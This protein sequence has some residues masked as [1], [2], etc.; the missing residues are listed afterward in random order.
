V[1]KTALLGGFILLS[2]VCAALAQTPVITG[3]EFTTQQQGKSVIGTVPMC[4]NPS[5]VAVPCSS[6]GGSGAIAT[7][8]FDS[9]PVTKANAVSGSSHAA[10]VSV[11]GLFTIPVAR[12]AGGSGIITNFS[13]TSP[14]GATVTYAVR[15]WDK[16]PASTTCTDNTNFAGNATDDMNLIVPP[17]SITPAPP[18]STQG[19]AKTYASVAGI[20]WDYKNADSPASQNLYGC[21]VATATDTADENTS[22]VMMLAGPQN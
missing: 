15:I 14:G 5:N 17:F 3:N 10:G 8:G 6:S 7:T 20:T 11:G 21:V 12:I 19:D 22:P 1:I 9:G 4:L 13:W 18:G 16:N 2:T